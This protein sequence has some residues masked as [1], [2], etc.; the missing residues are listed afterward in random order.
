MSQP[1]PSDPTIAVA[2]APSTALQ[3][4]R[5]WVGGLGIAAAI[6]VA[7][8][9]FNAHAGYEHDAKGGP[10][11]MRPHDGGPMLGL[12]MLEGRHGR[13]L[14]DR[15]DMTQAQK[16]QLQALSQAHRA[17]MAQQFAAHKALRDEMTALLK[18]PAL[19]DA[20]LDALRAKMLAHHQEM[21]AKRWD[22]GVSMARVLT[23]EQRLKL[24]DIMAQHEAR[25][26]A[27]M[28]AGTSG[29]GR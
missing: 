10:H 27:R 29:S 24:A 4:L 18:Q 26:D 16:D 1:R 7:F 21:A 13:R 23:A 2:P 19:D 3:R 11:A 17:D 9:A 8:T 25:H 6:M 14:M 12:P 5:W 15:L 22:L 20:A 28:K